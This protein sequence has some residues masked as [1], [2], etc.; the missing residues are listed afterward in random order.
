[1]IASF[2]L[3]LTSSSGADLSAGTSGFLAGAI[4][5][6]SGLLAL[7]MLATRPVGAASKEH[8]YSEIA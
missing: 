1:M 5:I 2:L 3:F 7:T 4:L 8:S 6:G